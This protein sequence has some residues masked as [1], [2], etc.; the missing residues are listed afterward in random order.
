MKPIYIPKS[1]RFHRKNNNIANFLVSFEGKN[2]NLGVWE[3]MAFFFI[4]N[5]DCFFSRCDEGDE[6]CEE[7]Y[8]GGRCHFLFLVIFFFFFFFL[9]FFFFFFFFFFL[10]LFLSFFFL[11]G[12]RW[13][14]FVFGR[15]TRHQ[16]LKYANFSMKIRNKIFFFIKQTALS[17]SWRP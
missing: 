5:C 10:C 11:K 6:G 16:F 7:S 3:V 4:S 1:K 9:F 12:S 17:A 13:L 8:F 14:C 2:F 15:L